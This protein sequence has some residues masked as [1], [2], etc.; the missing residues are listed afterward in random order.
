M[1]A[2]LVPGIAPPWYPPSRH[3]G[4][5]LPLPATPDV[6]ATRIH[7]GATA[8]QIWLWGSDPSLN[9]LE[10]LISGTLVV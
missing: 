10:A 5:T 8:D 4:Y 9:S 2:G 1:E 6:T 7:A 3:P